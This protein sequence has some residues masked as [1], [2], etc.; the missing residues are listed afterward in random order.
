MWFETLILLNSYFFMDFDDFDGHF[1]PPF[2]FISDIIIDKG[3]NT[4]L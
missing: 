3:V 4:C 2:P 1:I